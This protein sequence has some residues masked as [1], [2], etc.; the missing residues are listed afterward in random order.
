ME[1]KIDEE[2]N[3]DDS[4]SK[5]DQ[6]KNRRIKKSPKPNRQG[7]ELPSQEKKE[8]PLSALSVLPQFGVFESEMQK[9]SRL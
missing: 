4:L 3:D 2:D 9:Q 5:P 7:P 8:A 1:P 6:N